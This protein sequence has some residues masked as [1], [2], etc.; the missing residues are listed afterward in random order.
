MVLSKTPCV[1]MLIVAFAGDFLIWNGSK[2]FIFYLVI[3]IIF[4]V[5]YIESRNCSEQVIK[6]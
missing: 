3:I 5:F 1:G 2:I 4:D 6:T